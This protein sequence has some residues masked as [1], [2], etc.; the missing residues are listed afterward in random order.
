M[1]N[2]DEQAWN[3]TTYIGKNSSGALVRKKS[4]SIR[5]SLFRMQEDTPLQKKSA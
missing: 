2:C 5:I 3:I 4:H 1:L